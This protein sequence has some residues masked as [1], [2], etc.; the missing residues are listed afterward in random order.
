MVLVQMVMLII[1]HQNFTSNG[2]LCI[3]IAR[4]QYKYNIIGC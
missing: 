4:M 1:K 3:F 2:P